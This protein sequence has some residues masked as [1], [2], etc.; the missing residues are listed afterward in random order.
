[1]FKHMRVLFKILISFLIVFALFIFSTIYNISTSNEISSNLN[2]F[3]E[4]P[5]TVSNKVKE[6]IIKLDDVH[7]YL[8]DIFTETDR[9]KIIENH[10]II[11]G[12]EN[13]I[14]DDI[15]IIGD[16]FLGEHIKVTALREAMFESVNIHDDIIN[17]IL[18][19]K[20]DEAMELK[21]TIG[22][23]N[24][25]KIEQYTGEMLLVAEHYASA[26]IEDANSLKKQQQRN[27]IYIGIVSFYNDFV[28][29]ILYFQ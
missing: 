4:H 1:M 6:V 21:N 20:Y 27:M 12:V 8:N 13:E 25:I 29:C 28:N 10:I 16:R 3:N 26:F 23:E 11:N 15:K 7:G 22:K 18:D 24:E 9:N 19:G 17:Y 2:N 14:I 5:F